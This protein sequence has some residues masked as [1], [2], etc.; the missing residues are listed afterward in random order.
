VASLRTAQFTPSS[1]NGLSGSRTRGAYWAC[2]LRSVYTQSVAGRASNSIPARYWDKTEYCAPSR[3]PHGDRHSNKPSIVLCDDLIIL[4]FWDAEH[5]R[6]S[7]HGKSYIRI[8]EIQLNRAFSAGQSAVFT[9]QLFISRFAIS[10]SK[11]CNH[12]DSP[13]PV[14]SGATM[15]AGPK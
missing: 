3:R 15:F 8:R 11:Y 2:Q 12:S 14:C 5:Q 1:R 4:K 13:C 10:K 6:T 7:C 9:S